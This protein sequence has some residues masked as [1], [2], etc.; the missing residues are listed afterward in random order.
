MTSSD[1]QFDDDADDQSDEEFD[2]LQRL[3]FERIEEFMDDEDIR[4]SYMVDLLVDA[5]VRLRMTAYG[6]DVEK[7]SVGGLKLDLDR[8]GQ[9]LDEIVRDAKKEAEAYV[10]LIKDLRAQQDSEPEPE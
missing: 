9:D 8:W 6:M 7:P 5:A 1:D 4:E 2:R 10:A 3:L